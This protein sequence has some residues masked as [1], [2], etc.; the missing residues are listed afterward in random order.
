[1][2]RKIAIIGAGPAGLT[3]A[4]L[5][6]KKG[7]EVDVYETSN[8]PGGLSK[9]FELWGQIVDLGPHRFFTKDPMVNKLWFELA[10]ADHRKVKRLTRIYYKNKFFYYPLKP[11]DALVKLGCI[12]SIKCIFSMLLEKFSKKRN[13]NNFEEWVTKR[14]GKRLY[15]IF[16]KTYSEKLWGISCKDLD[17][18]F[19]SQRIKKLTLFEAI[20]NAFKIIKTDKHKTLIDEFNY[21][22]GGTGMIYE[23]M[24]N[25]ISDHGNNIFYN[26]KITKIR[27]ENKKVFLTSAKGK[28]SSY[29]QIVSTMP[30][31]HLIN[32]MKNVPTNIKDNIKNLKFRNTIL[33]YVEISNKE[34]FPDNWIYIHS[35]NLKT[36][37]ITNFRNW[38]PDICKNKETTILCMEYWSSTVDDVWNDNILIKNIAIND[39]KKSKLVNISNIINHKIVKLKNSYPIY[40]CGYKKLLNPIQKYLNSIENINV[41]GRYGS[42]KYNN[43]DH[44]ILMGILAAEN[45]YDDRKHNLWDINTDYEY[46]EN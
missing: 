10:G 5:L 25:Y 45:I 44:S 16:F 23:R 30:L 38:V 9:S 37:R 39:L 40:K 1:M 2:K 42:F 12:E 33:V 21:P 17:S 28:I 7:Y 20:Y 26:E 46:Q 34:I 15:N 14:F 22:K 29:G 18:D 6:T 3:T 27:N 19:A 8:K 4:Y 24:A 41:I 43:Q 35:E 31:T 11:V 13:E 32:C 36:G